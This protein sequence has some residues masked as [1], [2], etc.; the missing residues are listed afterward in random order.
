MFALLL[1]ISR[2]QI[3]RCID[4]LFVCV[5]V[6]QETVWE[7]F[8]I[9]WDRL[10][11][12]DEYQDWVNRCIDGS[13]SVMDIGS[14]F[15][16]SEE[17]ISLIRSVSTPLFYLNVK[18]SMDDYNQQCENANCMFRIESLKWRQTL[19][20]DRL[21]VPYVN[22]QWAHDKTAEIKQTWNFKSVLVVNCF[23]LLTMCFFQRVAMATATNRSV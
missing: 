5:S 22:I 9:F 10:P 14:F 16:Q 15:S 12:R 19:S 20:S 8:K 2:Q 11:D 21:V 13:I 18:S 4:L 3:S 1:T 7:A 6:C 23:S 17:H